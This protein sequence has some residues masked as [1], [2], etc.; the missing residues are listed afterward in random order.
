M[1]AQMICSGCQKNNPPTARF[2]YS[3][4]TTL[5]ELPPA[6]KP[7][8]KPEPELPEFVIP[9]AQNYPYPTQP[10]SYPQ[11]GQPPQG[12]N[13]YPAPPRLETVHPLLVGAKNLSQDIFAHPLDYY[14][15][16]NSA[17]QVVILRK[18]AVGKRLGAGLIDWVLASVPNIILT[19][20]FLTYTAEGQR[21][22]EQFATRR[23]NLSDLVVGSPWWA[24]LF[25]T[26]IFYFYFF[27]SSLGSGQT[28]GKRLLNARVVRFDGK[29]ADSL[30]LFLRYFFGY[31]LS[32]SILF[33]GF[34]FITIDP[35]RQGWHDKLARTHVVETKELIEGRDFSFT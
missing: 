5:P 15:Y 13:Y 26:L 8:P 3:C 29:K 28:P 16:V 9:S 4:G 20:I 33:I 1:T 34:L 21:Y 27:L 6:P 12:Y 14:S 35:K 22:L 11:T 7:E 30:T 17:G 2:C 31:V 23:G 24:T 10:Y 19:I 25:G 18:A 32:S